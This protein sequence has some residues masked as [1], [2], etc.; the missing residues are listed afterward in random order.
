LSLSQL[1]AQSHTLDFGGNLTTLQR[2][3]G[4]PPA[5]VFFRNALDNCDRPI[6]T[7]SRASTSMIKREIVQL[8]RS[9]TAASSRGVTTRNAAWLLTGV[10]PGAM[11]A[12]NASTPP[13]T[14]SPRQKRT[15]SSRTPKACAM[16]GLVQPASVSKTAR[17]RSASPRSRER[18]NISRAFRCSSPALTGDFPAMIR[19]R[20]SLR[21]RNHTCNLLVKPMEPA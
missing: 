6:L 2:V 8:V 15:V 11:V 16:R 1:E 10:G 20:K 17:A 4:P 12:F 3:A 21:R 9:A 13:R 18:A 19:L 7:P 5:E 14:K